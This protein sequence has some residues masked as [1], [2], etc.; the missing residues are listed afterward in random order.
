M[1]AEAVLHAQREYLSLF[2][3]VPVRPFPSKRKRNMS[4]KSTIDTRPLH[5]SQSDL[6]EALPQIVWTAR[7]DGTVDWINQE[8]DRYTGIS[9]ADFAAGDWLLAVHPDDRDPTLDVWGKAIARGLPYRTEFRVW[10]AAQNRW[11]RHLV[12]ARPH[13][14]AAGEIV[15]WY[16]LTID[17]QELRDAEE[18]RECEL[19][20][21]IVERRVLEQIAAGDPLSR[22]LTNICT[23]MAEVLENSSATIALVTEDGRHLDLGLG[24]AKMDEWSRAVGQIPIGEQHGSSGAAVF[25]KEPVFTADIANDP[26]WFDYRGLAAEHGHAACWS[27]PILDIAGKPIACLACY[28]SERLTP[29]KA[30]YALL[31]RVAE[32]VST[33]ISQVEVRDQLRASELRYRSLFD[34]VPIAIWELDASGILRMIEELRAAG[35]ADFEAWLDQQPAITKDVLALLRVLDT[36]SAARQL[37]GVFDDDPASMSQA[38]ISMADDPKFCAAMRAALT[39]AWEGRNNLETTY[40]IPRPDGTKADVLVRLLLPELSTGR[41]L[42]TELDI[43][44]QRRIEERFRH[45]AQASSD[46]I[47]DRDFATETTW[48]N[49][50]ASWLSDYSDGACEVP[51]NAWVESVHP[52]DSEEI[53]KQIS[54]AISGGQM[55]WEGEYRLRQR[56]GAY[57]PV[58]ERAT[59]LRDDAGEPVRM[60]GNI[61]NL[62][63]QKALE[64]QLRQSQRLDAVGQLTGGIAHDFNN[65]LT[66]ILGNAEMLVDLLPSSQP[67][68][69]M[70]TQIVTASERAADLTQ[71]LL[72][73][74]R[75]QPLLPGYFDTNAL[76]R[77][78]QMLIERSITPAITLELDLAE[79]LS[80]VHVDRSMFESALLNLCVNARDAMPNGGMLRIETSTSTWADSSD[81]E[82]PAA[83]KYVRVAVSDHG[84]GMDADTLARV[85]EP[86]FTTKPPGQGSGLGLSMVHG[87]VHQ[88]GGHVRI[89]SDLSIGTT[90]ELLLPYHSQKQNENIEPKVELDT[91]HILP[92]GRILVVEDEEQ[93][94]DYI[95]LIVE[96]LG[97]QVEAEPRAATALIRL[98][99]GEPFDLV[100]SDVV[101]PGGV[102]GRELAEVVLN[103]RQGLPVLLVSG[104]AEEIADTNRQMDSRIGFLRKPFRKIDLERKLVEMFAG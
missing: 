44:E 14:D 73:F 7:P 12:D 79:N 38:L 34:V 83:G 78:M 18:E 84:E 76:V 69:A 61:I 101:M 42:L 98:R 92:R 45:V 37:H 81:P 102:S 5:P 63:K 62:S 26:L 6:A 53:L 8:F 90:V 91:P 40:S 87:F 82:M 46:Y 104:H 71:R 59:I 35:I 21:Q 19:R 29:T 96:S 3:N 66:V 86:F 93:V 88:S 54:V 13:L 30:Q 80:A 85:F 72:A 32:S 20:L 51:R 75:K 27:L 11:C 33:A 89:Q 39:A 47:F 64:A 48:V 15:R 57:I 103:E 97:Y 95:S 36:N 1:S 94:R 60:I 31:H 56:D 77:D 67:S 99:S 9:N 16:G 10:C 2:M 22:I 55:S 24:A 49:D 65:L 58:L 4:L 52:E 50:A 68:G 70:A 25:R 17:I 23:S 28:Y 100:L 41:L 74:A 43:T